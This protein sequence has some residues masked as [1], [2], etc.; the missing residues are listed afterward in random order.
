MKQ[1]ACLTFLLLCFK[2]IATPCFTE[3]LYGNKVQV[4]GIAS[5]DETYTL[6]RLCKAL[7][8]EYFADT[9]YIQLQFNLHEYYLGDKVIPSHRKYSLAYYP[10]TF[11]DFDRH[12][13][14]HGSS[15]HSA[16]I[17]NC[18]IDNLDVYDCLKLIYFG[19][20]QHQRIAQSQRTLFA[21]HKCY[22]NEILMDPL[23]TPSGQSAH[24]TPYGP[25]DFIKTI[26]DKIIDSVLTG[27]FPE[28]RK[29]PVQAVYR[30]YTAKQ[31]AAE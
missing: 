2:T 21:L 8:K 14:P 31:G 12:E 4:I 17:L 9:A 6:F 16:V 29:A 30:Q 22:Q 28:L 26:N 24:L 15:S 13:E 11:W 7:N 19:L 10:R 20:K 3:G 1:I 18:A 27:D 25:M 23:R 5:R